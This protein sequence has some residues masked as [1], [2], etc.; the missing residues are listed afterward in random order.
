VPD[1]PAPD[2]PA[3]DL[4][5]PA[6]G[7]LWR[8]LRDPPEVVHLDVAACGR[9]SRA[10]LAA[11]SK[12]AARES[13]SGGY[14]AEAA[15]APRLERARSA[16]ARLLGNASL[17]VALTTGATEGF[18]LLLESW[19]LPTGARVGVLPSEYGGNVMVLRAAQARGEVGVV[20]LPVDPQGRV[21]LEA[22]PGVLAGLDLVSLTHL[23]S[24]RGLLQPAAEVAA[25]C[26]AAGV[27]LLLDAAQTLGQVDCTGIGADAVVGTSR[28]WLCGPRGVGFVAV[29]G[30]LLDRL[31][32]RS[33][34][35]FGATWGADGQPVPA[36]GPARLE[37]AEVSVAARVGLAEALDELERVGVEPTLERLAALGPRARAVLD[38]VAGWRVGEPRDEPTAV[39]TL[40]AP[41]AATDVPAV[42]ARL[43]EAGLL[44]TALTRHRAPDDLPR[45]GLRVS[46]AAWSEPQDVE[47]LAREL[48][49][50]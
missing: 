33:P 27:P 19:P 11:M 46:L 30:E 36:P 29:S 8:D 18:R 4:P 44:V 26:R 38:G 20:P 7:A 9:A 3:P 14:V 50:R 17:Q 2:L 23:P 47:R 10:V 15:A 34:G 21:D 41:R 35:L 25:A 1:L 5:W 32:P 40:L 13:R 6:T 37:P 28:K 22:L 43:L 45:E 31:A 39:V 16:V 12:H 49:R 42:R 24:H 48:A